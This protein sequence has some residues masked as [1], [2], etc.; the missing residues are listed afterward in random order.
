MANKKPSDRNPDKKKNIQKPKPS[1][2]RQTSAGNTK[3]QNKSSPPKSGKWT[4]ASGTKSAPKSSQPQQPKKPSGNQN[5]N[6]K[7]AGEKIQIVNSPARK[8]KKAPMNQSEIDNNTKKILEKNRPAEHTEK[9]SIQDLEPPKKPLS[10]IARKLRTILVYFITILSVIAIVILLSLTVFFKIDVIEVQGE[11]RYEQEQIIAACCIQKGDNLFLSNTAP[12]EEK[13]AHD[14]PYIETV[15]I[16]KEFFNKIIISVKEA[17]PA[18]IVE[19]NGKYAVLS[20]KGKIL[21]IDD[22]KK[23]SVP[24]VMG[25]ELEEMRISEKIVYKEKNVEKYVQEIVLAIKDNK[26]KDIVTIDIS[27]LTYIFLERKDGFKIIIGDPENIAYKL[28][29]AKAI[30]DKNASS[31]VIS[32]GVDV[33]LASENGGKSYLIPKSQI[34]AEESSSSSSAESSQSSQTSESSEVSQVSQ[35]PEVSEE[36][37]EVPEVPDEEEPE[38][39]YEYNDEPEEESSE[40]PWYEEEESEEET[41]DEDDH[42]PE[43]DDEESSEEENEE[44]RE[45]EENYDDDDNQDE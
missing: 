4:A 25:A 22:S 3:N 31:G 43:Y 6:M 38:E 41:S 28:R 16:Q 15:S 8:K 37:P 35:E 13:I 40:E 36:E 26:I 32:D 10:P 21:Q 9:E 29:T 1:G 11:T 30:M 42:E 33:S 5:R 14:F 7:K 44:D 17:V 2:N 20:D 24:I 34:P 23:F 18:S 39:S 45:D 19:S 12:G 27:K